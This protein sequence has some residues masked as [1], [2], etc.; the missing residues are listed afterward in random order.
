MYTY[1]LI[2]KQLNISFYTI[3]YKEIYF[4]NNGS[5]SDVSTLRDY[6]GFQIEN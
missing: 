4:D 2:C 1:N 3:Q 5:E 6:N